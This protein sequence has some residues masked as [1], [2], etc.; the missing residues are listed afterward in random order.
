MLINFSLD[1]KNDFYI[2]KRYIKQSNFNIGLI[3]NIC[4]K[5]INLYFPKYYSKV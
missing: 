4:N 5:M 2:R 3:N 1:I